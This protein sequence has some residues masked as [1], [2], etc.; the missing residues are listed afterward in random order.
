VK[1]ERFI[2]GF[3]AS[4]NATKAARD[5]GYRSPNVEGARLLANASIRERVEARRRELIRAAEVDTQ[6]IIGTLVSQMR[7]DITD[8][9]D[10]DGEIDFVAARAAN[11]SHLIK[12]YTVKRTASEAGES[13]T[14][15]VKLHD[16]QVAAKALCEVFGLRQE[17][18]PNRETEASKRRETEESVE[19]VRAAHGD[20]AAEEYRQMLLD[21]EV[22]GKYAN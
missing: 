21:D 8:L 14:R 20:R 16:S 19:R 5:A 22:T 12:E 2:E 17:P 13:V 6:E 1:R 15:T 9:L 3:V 10:E 4:G 7:A 11:V 18:R